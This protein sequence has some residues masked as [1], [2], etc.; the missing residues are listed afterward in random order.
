[1]VETTAS[2][3]IGS[4][5]RKETAIA[6]ATAT[7]TA[8]AAAIAAAPGKPETDSEIDPPA[9]KLALNGVIEAGQRLDTA[10]ESMQKIA[11]ELSDL[12]VN[13]DSS[14]PDKFIDS[15][16]VGVRVPVTSKVALLAKRAELQRASDDV[17]EC[18][19]NLM[20]HQARLVATAH[21]PEPEEEHPVASSPPRSIF[22]PTETEEPDALQ[23]LSDVIAIELAETVAGVERDRQQPPERY[24][25]RQPLRPQPQ[26]PAFLRQV[27]ERNESPDDPQE[28][29]I[30]RNIFKTR[31][32]EAVDG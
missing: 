26:P 4:D 15:N 6:A 18:V 9:C 29:G 8:A 12:R 20:D 24:V 19:E 31:R 2:E 22:Q 25:P 23:A 16:I 10:K 11:K 7:V 17:R 14:P 27:V 3:K 13:L 32:A 28:T 30:L 5:E 21:L 1:M